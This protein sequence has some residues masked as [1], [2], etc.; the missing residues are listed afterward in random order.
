MSEDPSFRTDL[1]QGTA[2]D[3]DSFRLPYP[4]SLVDDLRSRARLTGTGRLLDLACGTGQIAFALCAE[5]DE[6]TAL[7]QEPGS[8]AFGQAKA[9]ALRLAH[10]R[11]QVGTAEEADVPGPFDM[12]A[13]GNAFHRLRRQRVAE[14]A[15]SWLRS[16]GYVAL[17]WGGNPSEGASD[18]QEVLRAV[19]VDWLGRTG[20]RLPA[21][22]EE[23][24]ARD[25]HEQVLSRVGFNY[26][27]S[28]DFAVRHVWTIETL[29]GYLYSTSILS[30]Q[31]LGDLAHSFE[32]DLSDRIL[33]CHP[34]GRLEQDVRFSYQLA[35]KP[36]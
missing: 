28:H 35:Q 6:I 10:I 34:N 3:Y 23:A 25:P 20:D 5:F 27:G 2:R 26:E 36:D 9:E 21:D 16:G 14:R 33:R 18:W 31:A 12:V 1:Y 19:M 15:L 7:D 11:W 29:T 22:W 24:M 30:R 17:L 13:I 32:N 4:P 8:V